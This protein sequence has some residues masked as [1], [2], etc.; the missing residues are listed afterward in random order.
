MLL[1][2]VALLEM[3]VFGT[4]VAFGC[5]TWKKDG[6]H[7]MSVSQKQDGHWGFNFLQYWYFRARSTEN[8][9]ELGSPRSR[10]FLWDAFFLA[11]Y[12]YHSTEWN[13]WTKWKKHKTEMKSL[14]VL[15]VLARHWTSRPKW[16]G[17]GILSH[18]KWKHQ[19]E[20]YIEPNYLCKVCSRE[21]AANTFDS[22]KQIQQYY[23]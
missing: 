14:D 9:P 21:I 5:L 3:Y 6:K 19:S 16:K 7:W 23:L 8:W 11:R 22:W 1:F 12:F 10:Y 20:G 4:C 17:L 18:I 15:L 2:G 13:I